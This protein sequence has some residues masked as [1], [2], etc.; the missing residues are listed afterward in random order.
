MLP[1]AF[2]FPPLV[3]RSALLVEK[4]IRL[5]SA[6]VRGF[7]ADLL[8]AFV[9]AA[10]ARV[11]LRGSRWSL[12]VLVPWG[13][14]C[15]ASYEFIKAMNAL[16]PWQSVGYLGD[17]TFVRGSVLAS[18]RPL[19][20]LLSVAMPA[21]LVLGLRSR[22][23]Q[24]RRGALAL[25][26]VPVAALAIA[27]LAWPESPDALTWRQ[28]NVVVANAIDFA[29]S[30]SAPRVPPLAPGQQ[31]ELDALFRADLS[32]ER[33]VSPVQKPANVLLVLLEGVGGGELASVA[34][35]HRL[36]SVATM[37]ELDAL[38]RRNVYFTSFVTH[39]RGTNRGLYASLCGDLPKLSSTTAKTTA[40]AAQPHG[41]ECLPALLRREGYETVFLQ[42][43]PLAFMLK[44][45]FLPKIG[46]SRTLGA[47]QFS[48]GHARS[49]WGVDDRTLFEHARG[50][51]RELRA[52]AAPWM[53]TVLTV[54]THH[55][56]AVP[57]DFEAPEP[58]GT[59]G[60]AARY[61]D[62]AV[63]ELVRGL[64][65]DGA[66]ADTVVLIGAD[67]SHGLDA[68]GDDLTTLLSQ[69]LS[70]FIA[71]LP[72]RPQL[73]VD[74][75]FTQSDTALSV[76]D[77]LD[78]ARQETPFLGRS[79]FRTYAAPRRVFVANQ[80]HRTVGMLDSR[81]RDVWSC[82][83]GFRRCD[84][85]RPFVP[86]G[87]A[88]SFVGTPRER[89]AAAPAE[90]ALLRAAQ[91]RA[92][93]AS[94]SPFRELRL[95]DDRLVPIVAPDGQLLF[96]GQYVVVPAD[97]A[98]DLDLEVHAVGAAASVAL[99]VDVVANGGGTIL[100]E[101]PPFAMQCGESAV[102]RLTYRNAAGKAALQAA[103]ARSSAF[104]LSGDCAL[105]FSR[106]TMRVRPAGDGDEP[107]LVLHEHVTRPVAD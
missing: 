20:L 46:F 17:G 12:A 44:D 72:G 36:P 49:N 5:S 68:T 53:M 13:L 21:L 31:A 60:R 67:E 52:Q 81:Q 86:S 26:S 51:V 22:P 93:G 61:A 105:K 107:G 83:E 27:A 82:D 4:G 69:H 70:F 50:V 38:G 87:A 78:L 55:P 25:S 15:C 74:D 65:A 35:R 95:A 92:D 23:P 7:V 97:A 62:L 42:A 2:A 103:E 76:L 56:F 19:L 71:V 18:S 106:A 34:E 102:L 77:L 14:V 94:L 24:A 8:V 79:L 84:H 63:A 41:A 6:D 75:V 30:F 98:M 32:G 80:N 66:L 89:A 64:E 59:F 16:P 29:R 33:V 58:V 88:P 11:A 99:G 3:Q 54:G 57:T 100:A 91:V 48:T 45:A 1:L 73:W 43:A 104:K 47:E 28:S 10:A 39:Q 37:P 9:L 90:V 40:I 85:L 96:A 101:L